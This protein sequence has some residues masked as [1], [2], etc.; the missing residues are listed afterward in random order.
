MAVSFWNASHADIVVPKVIDAPWS[1]G[2]NQRGNERRAHGRV[3]GYHPGWALTL[4]N[5]PYSKRSRFITLVKAVT[6]SWTN[7]F[8]ASALA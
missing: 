3:V 4:S 1:A 2:A 8:C 6:K 7:F 5:H